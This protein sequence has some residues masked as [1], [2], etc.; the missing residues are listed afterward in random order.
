M[1]SNSTFFFGGGSATTRVVLLTFYFFL[2]LVFAVIATDF[3]KNRNRVVTE[4]VFIDNLIGKVVYQKPDGIYLIKVGEKSPQRLFNYGTNP[5]WSPDGKQIAFLYGNAI[6]LFSENSG[7]SRQLAIAG[8]AKA[9]CFYPDGQS[10]VYTDNNLLRRVEINSGKVTTLLEGNNFYEV[11]MSKDGSR[12][13]ATV[14]TRTGFKVR[15]FVLQTGTVR[16]V[17]RGCSA[18]LSPDGNRVT[19]N[20]HKHRVLHLYQWENLKKVGQIHAPTGRSFDNQ[21]WSNNPQ[22]LTSTTEGKLNDIFLHH[23]TSDSTYQI[24]TSGD[25]DRADL[26][27]IRILP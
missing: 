16:T 4:S 14:K 7:K 1:Q 5:R 27:V 23:V 3:S 6:M 25:C 24:T 20:G 21:L 8:K 9:L 22:W 26:Y 10:V 12:L 11:D 15:I 2:F 13:A 19:V 17:S 18:S